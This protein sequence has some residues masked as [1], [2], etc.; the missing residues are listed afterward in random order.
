MA[1]DRVRKGAGV[2]IWGGPYGWVVRA[3]FD[4]FTQ[5][6]RVRGF[7]LIE[8]RERRIVVDG[9]PRLLIG[10]EVHYF[11]LA[12]EE[13]QDRLDKLKAAGGT[14]VGSYIP[15]LCHEPEPGH[16]DLDGHTR[17]ALDL[18][19]FID[20]CRDNDLLFFARP[21]PFVMAE[22]KNEGIPFYVY[23]R[24]P[25]I[26]PVGWDGRPD[27]TR[28]VDYLSPGF[29]AEVRRWYAAVMPILLPRLHPNGGSVVA[30]QLDNEV[31]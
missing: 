28:G 18:G 24:H 31:G 11:R 25:E 19:A 6:R 8:L 23:E 1:V 17:T 4:R 22:L 7:D 2:H 9:V 13:W 10:G 15:W 3:V 16:F 27:P 29:L 21:G 20:L 26:Q 5:R 14:M 30:V 12:R